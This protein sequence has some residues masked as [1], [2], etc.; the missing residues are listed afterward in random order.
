MGEKRKI[1]H[2]EEFE[3]VYLDS[4]LREAEHNIHSLSVGCTQWFPSKE[5][6]MERGGGVKE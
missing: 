2:V 4:A 5:H 1:S 3:I 6:S